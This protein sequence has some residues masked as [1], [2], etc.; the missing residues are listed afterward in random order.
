[1]AVDGEDQ[2][3]RELDAAKI[4]ERKQ[5]RQRREEAEQPDAAL[6]NTEREQVIAHR[7]LSA[8]AIYSVIRHEGEEELGRPATSLW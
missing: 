1:M 8:V 7:S 2:A 4:A 6:T 5:R 3:E